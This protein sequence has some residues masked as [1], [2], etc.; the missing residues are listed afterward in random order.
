MHVHCQTWWYIFKNL[1]TAVQ[2]PW[3]RS[4]SSKQ[5]FMDQKTVRWTRKGGCTTHTHSQR[6]S[7]QITR[8]PYCWQSIHFVGAWNHGTI[9]YKRIQ[10]VF[11]WSNSAVRVTLRGIQQQVQEKLP[12]NQF[13]GWPA[14]E[15]HTWNCL[16][17]SVSCLY[18]FVSKQREKTWSENRDAWR[19]TSHAVK[20]KS[21]C[22]KGLQC[23]AESAVAECIK[24]LNQDFFLN[25]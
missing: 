8:K 5:S 7:G 6:A 24:I 19:I 15:C 16:F 13:E 22:W 17:P 25:C 10:S 23:S 21:G 2:I 9:V 20:Q 18:L 1:V 14:T 11:R 12:A 3:D 4:F